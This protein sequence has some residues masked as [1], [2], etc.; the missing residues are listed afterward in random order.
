[1]SSYGGSRG[2]FSAFVEYFSAWYMSREFQ[3]NFSTWN[4]SWTRE[5]H[6]YCPAGQKYQQLDE[7]FTATD[8]MG[9]TFQSREPYEC[10]LNPSTGEFE[11]LCVQAVDTVCRQSNSTWDRTVIRNAAPKSVRLALLPFWRIPHHRRNDPESYTSDDWLQVAVW[12][13]V[14]VVALFWGVSA[15]I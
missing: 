8:G 7:E 14:S 13:I 5:P 3:E 4:W 15:M 2:W 1:M 9:R 6:L 12:W 11:R 10:T